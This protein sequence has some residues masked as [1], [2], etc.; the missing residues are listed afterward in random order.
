M[1]GQGVG[2]DVVICS[3]GVVQR[4]WVTGYTISDFE[5]SS[6]VID[7]TCTEADGST[8]LA[9]TR[10]VAGVDGKERALTPGTVQQF[11]YAYG[12]DGLRTMNYHDSQSGARFIDL[13]TNPDQPAQTAPPL[14]GA[15]TDIPLTDP[16]SLDS[17]TLSFEPVDAD[18][19]RFILKLSKV[20]WVGFGISA[21]ESVSMTAE[22]AGADVIVCSNGVVE[23]LVVS[24]RTEAAFSSAGDDLEDATCTYEEGSTILAFTRPI[25]AVSAGQ[26]ALRPDV[27]QQVIYAYG[28]DGVMSMRYHD[29][30][31]GGKDVV[32]LVGAKQE[33]NEGLL[34]NVGNPRNLFLP[35][36]MFVLVGLC[37]LCCCFG[38]YR[39]CGWHRQDS[40]TWRNGNPGLHNDD[41]EAT[42]SEVGDQ[43]PARAPT[44]EVLPTILAQIESISDEQSPKKASGQRNTTDQNFDARADAENHF[45]NDQS[46]AQDFVVELHS[47]A[48]QSIPKPRCTRRSHWHTH[49]VGSDVLLNARMAALVAVQGEIDPSVI[50]SMPEET[51]AESV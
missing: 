34:D 17:L 51:L 21:G 41:I 37:S 23:R 29:G 22:G 46:L 2:A 16:S 35:I 18:R 40:A 13:G 24:G 25:A 1:V 19:V 10:R 4:Y 36:S 20:A 48:C 44:E 11:I 9:F 14:P 28:N 12:N 6:E 32:L 39:T 7:A 42:Y 50:P 8:I 49:D 15:A 33:E 47:E 43:R 3:E 45:S 31:R 38:V 27:P 5:P 30:N 26:R